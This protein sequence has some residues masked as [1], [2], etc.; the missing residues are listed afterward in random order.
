M[1]GRRGNGRKIEK[2]YWWLGILA[3]I[4][5]VSIYGTAVAYH[6]TDPSLQASWFAPVVS[7]L[8]VLT[9]AQLVSAWSLARVLSELSR[10]EEEAQADLL[11]ELPVGALSLDPVMG[12]VS[13]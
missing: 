5:G 6:L 2:H 4:L 3:M 10:R 8:L 7:A 1:F 13:A 11:R 12:E 9:G